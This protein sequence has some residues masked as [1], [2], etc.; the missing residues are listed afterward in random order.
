VAVGFLGKREN[1][2]AAS[3][4]CWSFRAPYVQKKGQQLQCEG[5]GVD[6]GTKVLK[7]W[8]RQLRLIVS[9]MLG[10][11]EYAIVIRCV[12]IGASPSARRRVS[13]K[14]VWMSILEGSCG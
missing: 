4:V 11:R 6:P 10:A 12:L 1:S 13:S 14:I 2:S 3:G 9:P 7:V 8:G 5:E